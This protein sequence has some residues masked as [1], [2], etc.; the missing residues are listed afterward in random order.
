M[1]LY[2]WS[3]CVGGKI[4]YL[5]LLS[6]IFGL[7]AIPLV[8]VLARQ[9]YGSFAAFLAA[10]CFTFSPYEIYYSQEIRPYCV[11]PFLA[12][13]SVYGLVWGLRTNK[14]GYW[15]LHVLANVLLCFTHMVASL[16]PIV[17]GGYLLLFYWNR[18]RL[19]LGWGTL[20]VLLMM[21]YV[22]W[23]K[24]LNLE[25]AVGISTEA[26]RPVLVEQILKYALLLVLMAGGTASRQSLDLDAR[27][28]TSGDLLLFVVVYGLIGQFLI[29]TFRV[30]LAREQT[31]ESGTRTSLQDCESAQMG[32]FDNVVCWIRVNALLA[33]WLFVPPL[34][35]ILADSVWVQF[36]RV[37][38][39]TY[40]SPALYILLAGAVCSLR[41]RRWRVW[42]LVLLTVLY[43]YE[44]GMAKTCP[45]RADWRT[46]S[47]YVLAHRQPGEAV[48][49]FPGI[50]GGII[51]LVSA[52]PYSD[53]TRMPQ[54]LFMYEMGG[55]CPKRL[56]F[57][58]MGFSFMLESQEL[59]EVLREK[60][61]DFDLR[62][63]PGSPPIS[64]Y[65]LT[66]NDAA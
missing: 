3:K 58:V 28:P 43:A 53:L 4:V 13:L 39:F 62:V 22:C 38:Y 50:I 61:Y 29:R 5:R 23:I 63:I 46:A 33:L 16:L 2:F 8:F 32:N 49:V 7:A 27:L 41:L 35:V 37:R 66:P 15:A 9:F 34:M 57:W 55:I 47:E 45:M 25:M 64:V 17:E 26:Q 31:S 59:E 42:A 21:A 1:L 44:V 54:A 24:T 19:L 36:F 65:H 10:L 51:K 11:L 20:H 12:L 60:K 14:P 52:L 48:V 56:P 40:S 18:R 30:W 6:T